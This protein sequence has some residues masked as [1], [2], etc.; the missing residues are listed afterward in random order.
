MQLATIFGGH[1]QSGNTATLLGWVEDAARQRGHTVSR[2][3]LD[4]MEIHG[5][6]GCYACGE[7]TDEPGCVVKDDAYQAYAAMIE[8]DAILFATPLYMWS[9]VGPLKTFIDR[10][11]SLA[12][13][14]MT[15]EHASLVEG[16]P[17][18][19]LV[20]AG[21]PV[22]GNADAIQVIFPRWEDYLKVD[23][24]G[25]WVFPNCTTP[26]KLGDDAKSRAQE[27][28]GALLGG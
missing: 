1:R 15:P 9:Y 4:G 11:V 10:C 20:S 7:H 2:V 27:I 21:G 25:I 26:D 3:Q 16:K 28:V 19:L 14:Y 22:A 17:C 24:R 18:G 12:T 6:R 23:A 8:A 13:G 5:C